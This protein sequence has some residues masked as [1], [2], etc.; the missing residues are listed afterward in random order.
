MV[1]V[2]NALPKTRLWHRLKKEGRLLKDT[3][4]EN[5]DGSIN[6][7]P[8]MGIE[9][10]F[11]GYNQ[12]ISTI[13][14]P[15]HYFERINTFLKS[16]NQKTKEKVSLKMLPAFFKSIWEIGVIS[17]A[18]FYYWKLLA[19]VSLT[20]TK[21]LPLAIEQAIYWKHFAKM[22]QKNTREQEPISKTPKPLCD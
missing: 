1:G 8:K 10:L 12:I 6:F 9:N 13:Y 4:G 20:R 18:R 17:K 5:T 19:K 22:V 14:S 21:L 7:N 11:K 15:K 16:Y 3:S 2:L